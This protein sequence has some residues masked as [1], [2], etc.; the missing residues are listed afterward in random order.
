MISVVD[1][2]IGAH[3]PDARMIVITLCG[4]A[5]IPLAVELYKK[6]EM[7]LAIKLR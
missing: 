5:V 6:P 2:S 1:L 4:I 3:E 7:D